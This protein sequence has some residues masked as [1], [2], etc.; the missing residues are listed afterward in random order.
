MST[1]FSLA[2]LYRCLLG[3]RALIILSLFLSACGPAVTPA[4]STFTLQPTWVASTIIPAIPTATPVPIPVPVTP[5]PSATPV[6]EPRK[7]LYTLQAQ[8]NYSRHILVIA[9]QIDYTN[10]TGNVLSDLV[11]AVD[12]NIYPG[13]FKLKE[14]ML[15][16]IPISAYTLDNNQLK[17]SLANPFTPAQ[18]IRLSIAYELNLPV[19]PAPSNDVRASIFGYSARQSNLVD[20]YPYIVPY[21]TGKG[22]V[23][24]NPWFYGEHQVYEKSDYKVEITLVEPPANLVLAGASQATISGSQSTYTH[25][26]ARNFTFSASPMYQVFATSVGNTSITSYVFPFDAP[27]GRTALNDAAQALDLYNRLFGDYPHA[28]LSVVE[29]DFHDGMEYDGL[30]FLSKG[31][32]S[33]YDGTPKTYL[34]M[35]GVHE[36][37]HQWWY[38]RVADDQALE[39]WLDE[40]LATYSELL[41]YSHVHPELVK[42][43]W[44]Y[45][46]DYFQPAGWVNQRI[47]DYG[48]SYPYRDGVYLRGARFLDQLRQRMGDAVFMKFIKDYAVENADKMVT[49]QTFF[50]TLKRYSAVDIT[51]L[52]K[53]YFKP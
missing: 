52:L 32:Y 22:W 49:A 17:F 15:G 26:N 24:H 25:S 8:F 44:G 43:W 16:D 21:Q 33:T 30:F 1:D 10:N 31:F 6:V 48:G 12:P 19:I 2:Q 20:W 5:T 35:I 27:G 37:A 34:T 13:V 45:R 28:S 18:S 42:W 41:F 46:V 23:I 38:G 14:L 7:P 4:A 3:L 50:D 9:E 39:P 36:T 53:A 51:D 11:L 40:A 47:Y 29:A